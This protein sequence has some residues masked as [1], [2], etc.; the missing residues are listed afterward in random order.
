MIRTAG[1]NIE[2]HLQI[3]KGIISAVKIYGDFFAKREVSDFEK[4]LIGVRHEKD[5]VADLLTKVNP[6]DYFMG[7]TGED[8]INVMF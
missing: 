8:I 1:G 3:E 2:L 7:I 6:E 4:L 5:A